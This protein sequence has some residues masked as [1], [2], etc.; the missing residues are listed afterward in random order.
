MIVNSF[1]GSEK[2][3][4]TVEE[5][6]IASGVDVYVDVGLIENCTSMEWH[7]QVFDDNGTLIDE[8]RGGVY[9]NK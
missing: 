8:W 5:K 3:E 4:K 7:W 6:L 2:R 1:C 9:A